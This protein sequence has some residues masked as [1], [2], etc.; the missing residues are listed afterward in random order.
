MKRLS[1]RGRGACKRKTGGTAGAFVETIAALALAASSDPGP[2]RSRG[3]P[4]GTGLAT[5]C[6]PGCFPF[7]VVVGIFELSVHDTN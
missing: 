2:G 7:A 3:P 1:R 6:V 4:P 5:S